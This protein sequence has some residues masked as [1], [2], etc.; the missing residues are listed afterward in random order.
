MPLTQGFFEAGLDSLM[1]TD[2]RNRVQEAA[3]VA[4]SPTVA[5]DHPNLDRLASHVLDAMDLGASAG[6]VERI[7][8]DHRSAPIAIV[9]MGCR[10]PHGAADPD[11]FWALLRDGVDGITEV[12]RDRYDVER[13]FDP[14]PATPGRLYSR[15][16]GF[17]LLYTS[18]SPRD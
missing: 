9:G 6:E 18:P 8:V 1:A 17:C 3:G 2:L 10:F 11:A 12:P 14:S 4:L 13:Y 16:G 15:W 7:R 5:F